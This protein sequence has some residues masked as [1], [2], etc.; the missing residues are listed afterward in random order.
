MQSTTL[1]LCK[2]RKALLTGECSES[3]TFATAYFQLYQYL[4]SYKLRQATVPEG[5]EQ[6]QQSTGKIDPFVIFLLFL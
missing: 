2:I 4:F 5:W 3:V 1:K 6:R